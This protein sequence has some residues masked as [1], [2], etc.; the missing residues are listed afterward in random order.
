MAR[1]EMQLEPAIRGAH[2]KGGRK[3]DEDGREA[4]RADRSVPGA[5]RVTQR[6][7]TYG[8]VGLEVQCHEN[9]R[10]LEGMVRR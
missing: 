3:T 10:E 6:A 1:R 4:A 9:L 7:G 5:S 2:I 8:R